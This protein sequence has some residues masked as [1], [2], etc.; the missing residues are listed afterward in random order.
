MERRPFLQALAASGLLGVSPWAA[1]AGAPSA[2]LLIVVQNGLP[3]AHEL[4]GTIHSA[5]GKTGLRATQVAVGSTT[6][7]RHAELSHLLQQP[8]GSRLIGVTDDA[9]AVVVQA[10][11][12]SHGACCVL[13]AH[14]RFGAGVVNHCCHSPAASESLAWSEPRATSSI[15]TLYAQALQGK[16]PAQKLG[17]VHVAAPSHDVGDA[18]A[19]FLVY[20]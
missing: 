13:H 20:L 3:Q 14:H 18:L 6:P 10:I 5:L 17:P 19:S 4:A 8:R 9:T 16:M 7:L 2:G 12:A 1:H 11:A 15:G